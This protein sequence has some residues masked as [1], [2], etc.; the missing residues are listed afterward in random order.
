M[1]NNTRIVAIRLTLHW[2]IGLGLLGLDLA[3]GPKA[4]P[5]QFPFPLFLSFGF[6][7]ATGGSAFSY[8]AHFCANTRELEYLRANP[9]YGTLWEKKGP[10]L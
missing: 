7:L 3:F 10:I 4:N 2:L 8:C 6:Y 9:R 5:E 1:T